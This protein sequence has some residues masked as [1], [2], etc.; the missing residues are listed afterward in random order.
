MKKDNTHQDHSHTA[1][2]LCCCWP[3]RRT[4]IHRGT[5]QCH[6]L[7]CSWPGRRTRIPRGIVSLSMLLLARATHQNPSRHRSVSL[8][9]LLLAQTTHQDPSRRI[10]RGIDECHCLCC[11]WPGRREDAA[12]GARARARRLPRRLQHDVHDRRHVWCVVARRATSVLCPSPPSLLYSH[13][14][15]PR[16]RFP[17]LPPLSQNRTTPSTRRPRPRRKPSTTARPAV[18]A[19]GSRWASASG[20]STP[21]TT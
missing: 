1:K 20:S 16:L 15:A 13:T 3:G 17:R 21:T 10:P 6:C 19:R 2:R 11:G 7:C 9:M 14:T 5:A 12:C 8:S 4:R 18:A